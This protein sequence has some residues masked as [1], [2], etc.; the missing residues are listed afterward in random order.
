[1]FLLPNLF[2]ALQGFGIDDGDALVVLVVVLVV[3]A[4]AP[5]H[6]LVVG[7]DD[8]F[9]FLLQVFLEDGIPMMRY[10]P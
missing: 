9:N 6:T 8:V 5:R 2:H 4:A 7:L 3:P 1:M 10:S